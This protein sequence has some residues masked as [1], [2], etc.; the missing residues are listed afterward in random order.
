MIDAAKRFAQ[1]VRKEANGAWRFEN[2]SEATSILQIQT[3][4]FH[5]TIDDLYRNTGL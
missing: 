2:I 4:N 1:A 5:I 3:I